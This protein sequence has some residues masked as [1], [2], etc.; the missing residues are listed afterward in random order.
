[1]YGPVNTVY[2]VILDTETPIVV[3]LSYFLFLIIMKKKNFINSQRL[4]RRE[5]GAESAAA[6]TAKSEICRGHVAV[7]RF[8]R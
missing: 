7:W 8:L 3:Y 6:A 5:G 1:M 4:W 2:K